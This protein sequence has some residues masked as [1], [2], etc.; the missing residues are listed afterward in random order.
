[1]S[2]ALAAALFVA[3][4]ISTWNHHPIFQNNAALPVPAQGDSEAQIAQDNDLLRS[5]NVAL[6]EG[7]EPPVDAYNLMETPHPRLRARPELGKQ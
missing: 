5:V 4:G 2:W 3:I 7:E 1:L 6:L